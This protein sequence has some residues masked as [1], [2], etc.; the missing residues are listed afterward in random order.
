MTPARLGEQH[1]ANAIGF[2]IAAAALGQ[3]L[4]PALIGILADARGLE[5]I[6]LSIVALSVVLAVI[7]RVLERTPAPQHSMTH[8]L[9]EARP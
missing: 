2:Q 5:M 1:A 3:S 7:Y 9:A 4:L 6:A 8:V